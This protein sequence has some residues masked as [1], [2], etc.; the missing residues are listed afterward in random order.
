MEERSFVDAGIEVIPSH[1]LTRLEVDKLVQSSIDRGDEDLFLRKL[2]EAK[3]QSKVLLDACKKTLKEN[4]GSIMHKERKEL[5][6]AMDRLEKALEYGQFDRIE[7]D[8][9]YLTVI[10]TPIAEKI[11]E[12]NILNALKDKDISDVN[13]I[14]LE[15][16][17]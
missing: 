14:E 11:M 15:G 6:S 3:N 5:E 2:V 4:R 16:N 13:L 8:L 1:G 9:K 10:S 12:E 7:D 17:E